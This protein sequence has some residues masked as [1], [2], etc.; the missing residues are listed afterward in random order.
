MSDVN[1]GKGVHALGDLFF[2]SFRK[3]EYIGVLHG[4][5]V[6]PAQVSDRNCELFMNLLSVQYFSFHTGGDVV[7]YLL[8]WFYVTLHN[9]F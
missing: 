8:V 5:M 7:R 3:A 2:Y 9:A 6:L 1:Y 4:K